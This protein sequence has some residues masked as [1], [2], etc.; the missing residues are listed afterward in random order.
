MVRGNNIAQ[1]YQF[2]VTGNA[3]L[4]LVA[5]SQVPRNGDGDIRGSHW[6]IPTALYAPIEQQA[7]SLQDN[8]AVRGFMRFV[9]GDR[10]RTL[11]HRAG[12]TAPAP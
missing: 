7:V 5:L 12:Y 3:E 8:A 1:T 11:I 4:G 9:R 2:V 6:H 10:A